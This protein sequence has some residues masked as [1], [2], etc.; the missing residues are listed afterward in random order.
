LCTEFVLLDIVNKLLSEIW[1]T[2]CWH[3][4]LTDWWQKPSK[5]VHNL[6]AD[7]EQIENR[8]WFE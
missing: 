7:W 8:T 3:V 2:C 4:M 1:Q 6:T 5:V